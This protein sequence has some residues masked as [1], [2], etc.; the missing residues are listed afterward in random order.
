MAKIAMIGAGSVVF[1]SRLATDILSWPELQDSTLALMDVHQGRLETIA[2]YVRQLVAQEQLPAR[3][4]STP[5]RRAALEG[6]DYV[7]VMI[8]VGGLEMFEHDVAIPRRYGVDQT[9]GDTLGPGG[10]FRGLRTIPVL[11]D[12]CKDMAE[13]CPDALLVNY[14][15]PMAMNCWAMEAATKI[16]TLGLCHS[17]QG[18]AAQLAGFVAAPV[19]EIA[20]WVAGINHQAW[21]LRFEWKGEDAYPLLFEKM[22]D[23]AIYAKDPVR[24]EIM[25]HFDYFVT[26][27]SHHMSE[28][29]PWFR[30]SPEMVTQFLPTRWDYFEICKDREGPHYDRIRRQS[31]GEAAIPFDRTHEYCS[32]IMNAIETNT[33]FR[34]NGNVANTG[35]ITNLPDG[36]CV[37]VPI[38]VD[39]TGI[40]PCFVGDLPPQLAA[41]NRTNIGVQDL[42]VQACLTGDRRYV[43]QA[44]Q[45]DPLTGCLLTLDRIHDMVDELFA[46]EE[47]W[48][49]QFR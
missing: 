32:Y 20:Y 9:V 7:V 3:V 28:Y 40:Q 47:A 19:E 43:Y 48:L 13:L 41:I 1:A 42:A 27:S 21:F 46:A 36:C 23:P 18:T 30:K 2:G 35:L 24:F 38:L 5:D 31:R 26:E 14:S 12:I 10:V 16:W 44:I 33:P 39:N 11:L 17:V 49:P 25:R 8:Q 22:A 6:A 29:V 34:M 45:L 4:E 15:N 37:E